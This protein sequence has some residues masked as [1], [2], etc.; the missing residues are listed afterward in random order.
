M[1]SAADR[2][3][4]QRAR[5]QAWW[6]YG[7]V[8]AIAVACL[9]VVV[10]IGV[11]AARQPIA[12]AGGQRERGGEG[13]NQGD[14]GPANQPKSILE[15]AF[16]GV[17][18][19][20][21]RRTVMRWL[22]EHGHPHGSEIISYEEL[23]PLAVCVVCT[24]KTR[25]GYPYKCEPV[26]PEAIDVSR[27]VAVAVKWRAMYSDGSPGIVEKVLILD[28]D[29]RGFMDRA[30]FRTPRD[31]AKAEQ[32]HRDMLKSFLQIGPPEEPEELPPDTP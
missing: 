16:E 25:E 7:S 24:A 3:R 20:G 26:N 21:T 31:V 5:K 28:D 1:G 4:R 30:D 13:G 10:V 17:A 12:S 15:R 27:G 29:V 2:I 32:E 19:D 14:V 23:E 9:L 11:Y 6:I 22:A 18:G 8:G